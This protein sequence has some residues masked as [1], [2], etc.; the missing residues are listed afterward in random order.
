MPTRESMNILHSIYCVFDAV[1][2]CDYVYVVISHGGRLQ[3]QDSS[4]SMV[5]KTTFY[6]WK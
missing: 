6:K 3:E 5:H 2:V 4:S 1:D